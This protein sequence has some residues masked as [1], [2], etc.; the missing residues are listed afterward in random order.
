MRGR[1]ER[2]DDMHKIMDFREA[3][4]N[5][6]KA[7]RTGRNAI[8]Y[9]E[10]KAYTARKLVKKV[11]LPMAYEGLRKEGVHEEDIKR[12]LKVIKNRLKGH[13][14]STW[15]VSNYRRLTN[16]LKKDKALRLLTKSIYLNQQKGTPVNAWPDADEKDKLAEASYW[17]GHIMTTM[18]FTVKKN[19]LASLAT[20]IMEWNN[21]HHVPVEDDEGKL[22][23]LLTWTH[24]HKYNTEEHQRG[25]L[26]KDI[27]EVDVISVEAT[28]PIKEAI[29]IMKQNEIGCLP[30][31]Q[32]DELIG[33]VTIV[34][35]RPYDN[36]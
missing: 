29:N 30:V 32:N 15:M 21:I 10:G 24:A 12:L 3:K 7:A 22:C 11:F 36:D 5:F 27:M 14:G 16:T 28:T 23:G 8:M 31:T 20:S 17:I 35:V 6:M 9:W 2:F 25:F 13:T 19:D 4:S 34:D 26:V 33:I 18:L 1:P